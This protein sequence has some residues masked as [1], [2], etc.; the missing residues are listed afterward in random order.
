MRSLTSPPTVHSTSE[1]L[2]KLEREIKRKVEVYL[3][4]WSRSGNIDEP[5]KN[6]WCRKFRRPEQD[7]H[8]FLLLPDDMSLLGIANFVCSYANISFKIT[9]GT[10]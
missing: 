7:V 5:L 6:F 1:Q 8:V 2:Q 4:I 9:K 3:F 10:C